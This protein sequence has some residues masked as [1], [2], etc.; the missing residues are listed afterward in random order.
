MFVCVCVCVANESIYRNKVIN[1]QH[2]V[3]L[4]VYA[5]L[6]DDKSQAGSTQWIVT[7]TIIGRLCSIT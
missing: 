3:I 2:Y 1:S 7:T 6:S 4:I 5:L